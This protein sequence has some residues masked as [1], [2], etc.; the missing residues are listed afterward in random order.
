MEIEPELANCNASLL[1]RR[2]QPS[3][4]SVR[5]KYLSTMV[6]ASFAKERDDILIASLQAKEAV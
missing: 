4:R 6:T 2:S 5:I 1:P 3:G